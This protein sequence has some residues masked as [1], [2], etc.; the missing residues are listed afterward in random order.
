M[1]NVRPLH[2]ARQ[3]LIPGELITTMQATDLNTGEC[4]AWDSREPYMI[5]VFAGWQ[6]FTSGVRSDLFLPFDELNTV[7]NIPAWLA[8][9]E[10]VRQHQK[11]SQ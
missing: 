11:R 5:Q 10:T 1:S 2:V 8:Y 4:F 7:S 6:A 9:T 3:N